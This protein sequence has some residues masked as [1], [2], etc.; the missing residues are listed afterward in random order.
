MTNSNQYPY[1]FSSPNL[2]DFDSNQTQKTL[3]TNLLAVCGQKSMDTM[4][5][6]NTS[7]RGIDAVIDIFQE[8]S[9]SVIDEEEFENDECVENETPKKRKQSTTKIQRAHSNAK[10]MKL[11]R[12]G[13]RV[14]LKYS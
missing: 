8:I 6:K 4:Q 12:N 10:K 1:D 9:A 14:Q 13:N 11:R 7:P 3:N 5:T 2:T